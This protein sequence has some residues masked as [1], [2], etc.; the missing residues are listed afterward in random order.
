MV[1]V[2]MR[3]KPLIVFHCGR[4][5]CDV[6]KLMQ[7]Y[8]TLGVRAGRREYALEEIKDPGM[9]HLIWG[10]AYKPR[11]YAELAKH[12]NIFF[13]ENGWL[14]PED[15]CYFDKLGTNAMSSICNS[16]EPNS[17]V[18]D[19][20]V[21]GLIESAHLRMNLKDA[22]PETEPGDYI[23]VPLQRRKDSQIL[24]WSECQGRIRNRQVWFVDKVCEAFP[25][26]RIVL[27]PHPRDMA[28]VGRIEN[29]SEGFKKHPNI[30]FC[31]SGN[32]YQWI[33]KAKAVVGINS[34][35]LLEALTFYKP[36][37]AMGRGVFSGN[38]VLLECLGQ[39][40]R[41]R[42]VVAYKPNRK[43]INQFITLLLE[44]QI[45]YT[46]KREDI[47]RYPVFCQVLNT[48]RGFA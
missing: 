33:S 27:R 35:V 20:A 5:V 3:K 41:L 32:T 37:A 23:F 11:V 24:F 2:K 36:T 15:S 29:K 44:R 28:E 18:G 13:V 48:A 1:Q 42:D 16:I 6:D 14:M 31:S 39:P 43:R 10:L 9:V 7:L 8:E 19:G 45:P 30:S 25:N 22:P 47:A 4:V 21:R 40:E 34:T 17:P 38:G 12:T 26:E 46:L